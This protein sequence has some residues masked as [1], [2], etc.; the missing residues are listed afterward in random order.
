[1]ALSP[2]KAKPASPA[3]VELLNAPNIA[4]GHFVS[5]SRDDCDGFGIYEKGWYSP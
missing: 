1:M 3:P 5:D 4:Y 2:N